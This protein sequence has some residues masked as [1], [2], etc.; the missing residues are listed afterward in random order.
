MSTPVFQNLPHQLD[1]YTLL[2]LIESREHTDLYLAQQGHVGRTVILEILHLDAAAT[3]L[4][5][6]IETAQ[7]RAKTQAPRLTRVLEALKAQDVWFMAQEQPQ[8]ESLME[9]LADG[10]HLSPQQTAKLLQAAAEMYESCAELG[11]RVQ[12]LSWGDIFMSEQG[13]V[14]FLSSLVP[15]APAP[16]DKALHMQQLAQCIIPV[17]PIEGEG[18]DK[19]DAMLQW[20]QEGYNGQL[21]EWASVAAT[22][23]LVDSELSA[24][25]PV[26]KTEEEVEVEKSRQRRQTRQSRRKLLRQAMLGLGAAAVTLAI[27]SLGLIVANHR[28]ELVSPVTADFVLC[29]TPQ[30]NMKAMRH[31]VSIEEYNRFLREWS[32]MSPEQRAALNEGMP[33]HVTGHTPEHWNEIF[34]AASLHKDYQGQ[35]LSPES[36][37]INITYWN[38]LAYARYKGG[39]LPNMSTLQAIHAELHESGVS[40]WVTDT[41]E[42]DILHIYPKGCPMILDKSSISRP[43]PVNNREWKSLNLGFRLIFLQ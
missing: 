26:V 27:G 5:T 42:A 9:W 3:M 31:P 16:I 38:A 8:G 37:A 13:D 43:L 19:I 29:K 25:A 1:D 33:D 2:R 6:F 40:E 41:C 10:R 20:L 23:R 12:P 7:L 35:H 32:T 15:G 28:Q 24:L 39:E 14:S 4:S 21:L 36:P 34:V 11:K 17:R 22:A 18:A 30:G